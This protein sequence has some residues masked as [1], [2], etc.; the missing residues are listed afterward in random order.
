MLR[1]KMVTSLLIS[2]T[3]SMVGFLVITNSNPYGL[4]YASGEHEDVN[5]TLSAS[6]SPTN[7]SSYQDEVV[8]TGI[9]HTTFTYT[10]VKAAEGALCA[11]DEGGTISK[12]TANGLKTIN[13]NFVGSLQLS[14]GFNDSNEVVKTVNEST[15]L[16]VCG[17]Y[18]KITALEASVINYITLKYDC[19]EATFE[20][21]FSDWTEVKE[22][23][24]YENG[25]HSRNCSW[26]ATE[27]TK[28]TSLDFGETMIYG[29]ENELNITLKSSAIDGTNTSKVLSVSKTVYTYS[30]TAANHKGGKSFASFMVTKGLTGDGTNLYTM[31]NAKTGSEANTGFDVGIIVKYSTSGKVLQTSSLAYQWGNVPKINYFDGKLYVT[32]ANGNVSGSVY[33]TTTSFHNVTMVFDAETLDLI[34]YENKETYKFLDFTS[35]ASGIFTY[36]S[37]SEDGNKCAVQFNESVVVDSTTT[38]VRRIYLYQKDAQGK[39]QPMNNGFELS[40]VTN[41]SANATA[42]QAITCGNNSVYCFYTFNT[43]CVISV[44]DFNGNKVNDYKV[45]SSGEGTHDKKNYQGITQIN[46]SLYYSIATWKNSSTYTGCEIYKVSYNLPTRVDESVSYTVTFDTNGSSSVIPAQVVVSGTTAT[47]PIDPVHSHTNSYNK[48]YNFVFENWYLD[49]AVWDFSKNVVTSDITLKANYTFEDS[50]FAIDENAH[51]RAEG[52]NVRIMSYNVLA[53]DWNNKPA[54]TDERANQAF[55]TI[56]RYKPDVVGLQEFDDAW[57]TKAKTL[58]DGYT[59]VN[60]DSNKIG[61]NT[62]YSTLAYNH[63]VL[64]LIEYTQVKLTSSNDNPKCRNLTTGVF[65]YI[66]GENLGKKIIVSS[67]HWDLEEE[68]RVKQASEQLTKLAT[69]EEKYPDVPVFATGDYNSN[70]YTDSYNTYTLSEHHLDSKHA[71]E[72]KDVVCATTHL[73]SPMRTATRDYTNANHIFRGPKSFSFKYVIN[74]KCIDHIFVSN[75]V[76]VLYYNTIVDTD[77]LHSSDHCPIY[78]DYKI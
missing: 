1:K 41:G 57:Y 76:D 51:V 13:L 23:N 24:P 27:E 44:Y 56:E 54:V 46:G 63:E 43:G 69:W 36:L 31:L 12:D 58:F 53:D 72:V 75:Y 71:A 28:T 37:E 49:E 19:Y 35:N 60:A 3:V 50:F 8:Y 52:A 2:L 68:G 62:N 39:F 25:L 11:L 70:D 32:G 66:Q 6:H 15:T 26:C 20:H 73:G 18:F 45:A 77:A 55:N 34:S 64:S 7:E 22:A 38:I 5:L 9:D 67:T 47:K 16:N 14:T 4:T 48:T 21:S 30:E 10:K 78:S 17:N 33:T 74:E 40:S 59:I 61:S 65:E 42:S 29:K